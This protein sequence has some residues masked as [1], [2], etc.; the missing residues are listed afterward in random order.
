MAGDIGGKGE[1]LAVIADPTIL[2]CFAPEQDLLRSTG[3]EAHRDPGRPDPRRGR[4]A[5]RVGLND[6]DDWRSR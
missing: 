2:E 5:V 3:V 1:R 4:P 6:I